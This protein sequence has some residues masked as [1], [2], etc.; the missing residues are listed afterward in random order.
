MTG[1][2]RLCILLMHLFGKLLV[3]PWPDQPDRVLRLCTIINKRSAGVFVIG[4][5]TF[6]GTV[7]SIS[8]VS[9]VFGNY[10][11]R[12]DVRPVGFSRRHRTVVT[13]LPVSF[14]C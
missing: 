2:C 13:P 7:G 4:T 8:I 1:L 3:R 12:K 10:K 11:H 14:C 6:T 9:V 5:N